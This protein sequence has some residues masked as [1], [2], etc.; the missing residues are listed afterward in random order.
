MAPTSTRP[1]W[2]VPSWDL[3]SISLGSRSSAV[4]RS[5]RAP[6]GSARSHAGPMSRS[7]RCPRGSTGSVPP[8]ARSG[9]SK[10]RTPARSGATSATHR[11]PLM[12]IP[13]LLSLDASVELTSITGSRV[14]PL[15]RFL[16]GYRQTA[17]QPDELLTAVLI[18]RTAGDDARSAFL[19]LGLRRYLVISVVMVAVVVA[20]DPDERSPRRGSRSAHARRW[21]TDCDRSSRGWSAGRSTTSTSP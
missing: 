17:L 1:M 8:R 10:C 6:C 12:A 15:E 18:P 4:S 7:P 5:S 2:D 16:T 13:P 21:H 11:P 9:R 19:K 3:W 14:L 20:T